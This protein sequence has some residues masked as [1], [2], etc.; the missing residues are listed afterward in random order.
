M[1]I[2]VIGAGWY[3]CHIALSLKL[4]GIDVDIFE[5]K[6]EIFSGASGKNQY[7]L[8]QGFHYARHYRTRQQSRD[9][10]IRFIERY[11]SLSTD[12]ENN[13]YAVPEKESLLDYE[14]YRLIMSASGLNF[15]EVDLSCF[16]IV[17][18]SAG[19]RVE[20]RLLL[21][22]RAKE[23]FYR[24]LEDVLQTGVNVDIEKIKYHDDWVEIMGH[25]Y[26]YVVDATWGGSGI[27]LDRQVFFEPT[28]LLYYSSRSVSGFAFTAVDGDLCSVYPCE[29]NGLYTLSSVKYTPLGRFATFKEAEGFIKKIG[30]ELIDAKRKLMEEEILNYLPNFVDEFM[31]E[32]PQLSIKTKIVGNSDDRSCYVRRVEGF[33]KFYLGK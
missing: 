25:K 29:E 18:C 24:N 28:L 21:T 33:L 31:F 10:Y 4:L 19:M 20:E 3:G 17:N 23:F 32:A 6:D 2:A 22:K 26:D 30:D 12:I 13:I 8:H 14:T 16:G 7:R 11:P 27:E 1:K 5:R 15:S 9:G